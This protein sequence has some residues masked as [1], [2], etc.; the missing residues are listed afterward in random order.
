MDAVAGLSRRT[1]LKGAAGA[2]VGWKAVLDQTV[3]AMADAP[4][5]A[6]L[7]DIEHVVFV[8]QENR[9]FDH[10]F[11]RYPGVRGFDDRSVKLA[12]ADDGTT[13]FRQANPGNAPNPVLPFHINTDPSAGASG[14]CIHDIGHQWIEQHECWAN[15]RLD[16]YVKTHVADEGATFGPPPAVHS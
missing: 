11:G 6:G 8:I 12:S 5:C 9:S 4:A 7:A 10:Y 13:V 3:A 15:G 14:E 16:S 2:A 1:F